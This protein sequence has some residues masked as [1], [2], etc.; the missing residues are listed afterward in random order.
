MKRKKKWTVNKRKEKSKREETEGKIYVTC[1]QRET[2]K[3]KE[4][5]KTSRREKRSYEERQEGSEE[6][7]KKKRKSCRIEGKKKRK[8]GEKKWTVNK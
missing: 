5:E 1:D 7:R 6:Q 3:S 2:K 8:E 4:V